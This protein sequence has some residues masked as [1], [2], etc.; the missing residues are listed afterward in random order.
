MSEG[1]LPA[2]KI[3]SDVRG[4]SAKGTGAVGITAGFPCQTGV[5]FQIDGSGVEDLV[6]FLRASIKPISC[7]NTRGREL[8]GLD[9][10]W[11]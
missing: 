10:S 4:F 2:A 7:F 3:V 6:S 5:L 8:A 1:L 11:V 9:P